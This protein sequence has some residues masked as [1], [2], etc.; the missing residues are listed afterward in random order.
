MAERR[1]RPPDAE[2]KIISRGPESLEVGDVIE[3]SITEEVSPGPGK[4]AWVKFG[5]SSSVRDGETTSAA[6]ER[7]TNFVNEGI[8]RRINDLS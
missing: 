2:K 5:T 3:Y 1:L 6:V 7:V 4:K 8:D